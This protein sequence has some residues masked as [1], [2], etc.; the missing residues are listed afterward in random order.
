MVDHEV[1]GHTLKRGDRVL[2]LWAAG[3][4][5]PDEFDHPD[6]FDIHRKSNRHLSF[7]MGAHRCMGIHMARLSM[8]VMIEEWLLRVPDFDLDWE[9]VRETPGFT[10]AVS[11]L[12]AR[13]TIKE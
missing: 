6:E 13:W 7:G 3:N 5:D 12:P 11:A 1:S 9:N 8:R 4:R 10:W 2:L